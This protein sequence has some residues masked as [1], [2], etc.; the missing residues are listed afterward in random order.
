MDTSHVTLIVSSHDDR[1][2]CTR[3]REVEEDRRRDI[4]GKR[5][6]GFK[7][8]FQ[9][10][11]FLNSGQDLEL[12]FCGSCERVYF[13]ASI[14]YQLSAGIKFPLDFILI[15]ISGCFCGPPIY[16]R[17]AAIPRVGSAGPRE[18][19]SNLLPFIEEDQER[20]TTIW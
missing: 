17:N 9:K 20:D 7:L 4:F 18:I 12:R 5:S 1:H 2:T 6:K 13:L 15:F 16:L 11:D 8:C 19:S 14:N 10:D 3:K